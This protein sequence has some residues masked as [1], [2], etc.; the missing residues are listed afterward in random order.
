MPL[1]VFP[2]SRPSPIKLKFLMLMYLQLLATRPEPDCESIVALPEPYE[3]SIIPSDAVPES[4]LSNKIV[5]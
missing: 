2:V 1:P 5:P 4:K 3:L